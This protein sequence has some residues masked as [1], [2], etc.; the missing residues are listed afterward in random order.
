MLI[1]LAI[2]RTS[3]VAVHISVLLFVHTFYNRRS[4]EWKV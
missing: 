2:G 3:N 1:S 4:C